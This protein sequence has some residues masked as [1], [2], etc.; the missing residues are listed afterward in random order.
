MYFIGIA[1]EENTNQHKSERI[2]HKHPN[3]AL[4]IVFRHFYNKK[5]E[6]NKNISYFISISIY[7]QCKQHYYFVFLISDGLKA[8]V[9]HHKS[10]MPYKLYTSV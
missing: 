10:Q 7:K 3:N 5:V 6:K 4:F 2:L 8:T 9:E 1:S